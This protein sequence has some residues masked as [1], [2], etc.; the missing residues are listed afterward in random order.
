MKKRLL[1]IISFLFFVACSAVKNIQESINKGNYEKAISLAINKLQK[2]KTK[3]G[4]QAYIVLLEDSF[5]KMVSRDLTNLEY[6]KKDQ[7]PANFEEMYNEYLKLNKIQN[8][9]EPLLPLY[10]AKEGRDAEFLFSNYNSKII[11]YKEKVSEYLYQKAKKGLNNNDKFSYR[12][13]Y[14]DLQYIDEINSNYKDVRSLMNKAHNLGT[15]YVFV[16]MKN[17]TQQVIPRRL[18]ADLLNFDTYGINDFW[19][20]YHSRKDKNINYDFYLQVNLKSIQVSPE[21]IK[22]T[23]SIKEREIEDIYYQKDAQGNFIKDADGNKIQVI[24]K[25]MV[26]SNFNQIRQ[27]KS[28]KVVG[29][30]KYI[31]NNSKQVL[32]VYPIESE[33]IFEHT[34]ARYTGDK[35]ALSSR[36][37]K[38]S[39]L[40][41][42]QFPSNEQMIYDTGKD[43]K[44]RLKSIITRNKFRQ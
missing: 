28:S 10:I 8:N 43:L 17:Q 4:N 9:I 42:V 37:L 44:N 6:L 34:Y 40:R 2:N 29:Q 13:G 5:Q 1:L 36:F 30:V 35:R 12:K 26:R 22:E 11:E 32:H 23:S 18:E 20:L 7:N 31:D 16:S 14:D 39:R 33:F 27:F 38:Y 25:I 41:L 3:K 24:E 19:T 21:Q 15:D